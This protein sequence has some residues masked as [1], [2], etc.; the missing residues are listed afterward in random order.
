[1]S[2]EEFKMLLATVLAVSYIT[3]KFPDLQAEWQ[4]VVNKAS[5]YIKKACDNLKQDETLLRN[6]MSQIVQ[7]L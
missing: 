6:T 5:R 1:M 7:T 4:M 2:Q 3:I